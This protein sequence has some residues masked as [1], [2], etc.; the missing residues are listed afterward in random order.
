MAY[1]KI[2]QSGF[3]DIAADLWTLEIEQKGYSGAVNTVAKMG[4]VPARFDYGHTTRLPHEKPIFDSRVSFSL[5]SLQTLGF[6]YLFSNDQKQNKVI[7]KY[8]TNVFF[9]GMLVNDTYY[10]P[11]KPAPF[12][13]TFDALDGL[14]LL[15]NRLWDIS[16][17]I[18]GLKAITKCL[19]E[20]GLSLNFSTT[21]STQL[22]APQAITNPLESVNVPAAAYCSAELTYFEVLED[23]LKSY[24][25]TIKQINGEWEIKQFND[26][27]K[28]GTN[29]RRYDYNGVYIDSV[30]NSAA[31]T[32]VGSGINN[33]F[34]IKN[35]SGLKRNPS[36]KEFKITHDLGGDGNIIRNGDFNDTHGELIPQADEWGAGNAPALIKTKNNDNYILVPGGLDQSTPDASTPHVTQILG[37]QK[38]ADEM[39]IRM[40]WGILSTGYEYNRFRGAVYFQIKWGNYYGYSLDGIIWSWQPEVNYIRI[41]AKESDVEEH[42]TFESFETGLKF[43]SLFDDSERL[44]SVSLFCAVDVESGTKST[45]LGSVFSRIEISTVASTDKNRDILTEIDAN[46]NYTPASM[47]VYSGDIPAASMEE[48]LVFKNYLTLADG[49]LTEK[50]R[51]VTPDNLTLEDDLLIILAAQVTGLFSKPRL[52]FQANIVSDTMRFNS[53]IS[54]PAR[55]T[56]VFAVTRASFE[57]KKLQWDNVEAVELNVETLPDFDSTDF[58]SADFFTD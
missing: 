14:M 27:A 8:K 1:N 30:G 16:K 44:V 19:Q 35:T 54:D 31:L 2:I 42:L 39:K 41:G 26:Q 33:G 28:G 23:I 50:W 43:S 11:F 25:A 47:K 3:Y 13:V 12:F 57:P 58:D 10:E 7:V 24:G 52:L 21:I 36:F 45:V 55:L 15:K 5:E 46:S 37:M 34:I 17:P 48:R 22:I 29:R 49:S 53:L 6:D 4:G 38:P 32:P 56:A 51:Y 18:S 40:D 20:T 9:V